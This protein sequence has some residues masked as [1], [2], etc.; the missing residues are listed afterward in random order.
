V[1]SRCATC[2]ARIVWATNDKTGKPAP[3]DAHPDPDGPVILLPGDRYRVL[4][5]AE[6]LG[7]PVAVRTLRY[8]NHWQTCPNPPA[9]R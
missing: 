6:R 2:D 4:T 1:S 7:E 3:I 9:R 5:K 8:T